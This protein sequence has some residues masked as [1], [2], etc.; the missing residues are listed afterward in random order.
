MVLDKRFKD[1]ADHIVKPGHI[2]RDLLLPNHIPQWVGQVRQRVKAVP[3]CQLQFLLKIPAQQVINIFIL[4]VHK[5]EVFHLRQIMD[6]AK[7]KIIIKLIQNMI[8]QRDII[9]GLAQLNPLEH[10]QL[11]LK[12]PLALKGLYILIG[13]QRAKVLSL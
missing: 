1:L 13:T 5:K 11:T 6:G 12:V 9:N 4:I 7:H 8:C 10:Q 2:H 3:F